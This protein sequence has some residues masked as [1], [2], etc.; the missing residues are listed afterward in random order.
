MESVDFSIENIQEK[1][2]F[3]F[4]KRLSFCLIAAA[5]GLITATAVAAV[6]S[7]A[8]ITAAGAATATTAATADAAHIAAAIT[9]ATA[10]DK[11]DKNKDPPTAI[12]TITVHKGYLLSMISHY[13]MSENQKEFLCCGKR[14]NPACTKIIPSP[15]DQ[16]LQGCNE[17]VPS[18]DS[19]P[20]A[21]SIAP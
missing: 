4:R 18:L 6:V 11:Q 12:I 3:R 9:A 10:A 19:P 8:V 21:P 17:P 1:S 5:A 14:S 13:P 15:A 20:F 7:A 16:F 2:P